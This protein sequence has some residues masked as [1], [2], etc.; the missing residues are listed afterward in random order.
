MFLLAWI[1]DAQY[2]QVVNA[3][4]VP[5]SPHIVQKRPSGRYELQFVPIRFRDD[6]PVGGAESVDRQEDRPITYLHLHDVLEIGYCHSGSGVFVVEDKVLPFERGDVSIINDKEL[7]LAQS[8]E[9]T[10]SEWTWMMLDPVRLLGAHVGETAGLSTA[11]LCGPDF[12]NIVSRAEHPEIGSLV[13]EILTEMRDKKPGYR[14][15]VRGIVWSLM[16]RLHRLPGRMTGQPAD[17]K[18]SEMERIAPALQMLTT[19]YMEPIRVDEMAE[20][21]HMS[22]THFRR[23]FRL[24]VGKSPVQYLNHLR[25]QMASSLLASTDRPILEISLDVGFVTLSSFNRGFKAQ[26]G[27]SPREWRRA[28][29]HA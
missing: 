22:L 29:P 4:S 17:T 11:P 8:T 27:M 3:K 15:S 2:I 19:R 18:R 13:R 14:S 9:G 23:V 16:M 21:C 6:F 25:I 28:E 26:K 1:S 12:R 20:A 7:H 24:A 5:A 10:V